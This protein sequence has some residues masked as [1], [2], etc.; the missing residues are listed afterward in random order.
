VHPVL[1]NSE[2][3]ALVDGLDWSSTPFGARETWP[4]SLELA[5]SIVLSSGFP[6]ALRW[7]PD[8]V[9]IYNDAYRSIL[10]EKHPWAFGRSAREVWAEVWSELG[11]THEAILAGRSGAVFFENRPLRV[12]RAGA[13]PKTAHFTFSY[14]PVPDKTNPTGIGGILISAIE[15]TEQVQA[16]ARLEAA[17]ATA[18]AAANRLTSVLESTS[19]C[20]F[21]LDRDWRFAFLNNRAVQEIAQGRNLI[22]KDIW[23]EF[24]NAVGSPFWDGYQRAMTERV[25]VTFEAFYPPPLSNWYEAEAYPSDEGVAV[26]FRNINQRHAD[27]ERQS[28]LIRELHHRVRNTLATVQAILSLTARSATD[29]DQFY[30]AFTARITSLAKTH[31]ILTEAEQ[32]V[33]SL[34]DLLR[35]ELASFENPDDQRVRLEGPEVHL[36]SEIAVPFA[37][38]V[39][40]LTAN[41]ARYGALSEPEG[42]IDVT[43]DVRSEADTRFL[44]LEWVERDGPLV[45]TP[46]HHGFGERLLKRMLTVQTQADVTADY[47]PEGLRFVVDLPLK[48]ARTG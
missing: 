10:A 20:V 45:S 7:G 23:Q 24:P 5:V 11:P 17:E 41:A 25:P 1:S 28:L 30:E 15:T 36:P 43:W 21:I 26:F 13:G 4:S 39:H 22:G 47:R 33:A 9:M 35:L 34:R 14:S 3:V 38:A 48:A 18:R 19:D 31:L 12:D 27:R 6:M 42:R 16:K 40:E 8:F 32:Q 2:M 37:M 46:T 29:L 44:H